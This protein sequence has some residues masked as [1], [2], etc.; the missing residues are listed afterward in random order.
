MRGYEAPSINKKSFSCPVCLAHTGQDWYKVFGEKLHGDD[1]PYIFDVKHISE[2]FE[3]IE[4]R[5]KVTKAEI[6]DTKRVLEPVQKSAQ[7][8]LPNLSASAI[9]SYQIH[10]ASN[11]FFS[12]CHVCHETCVWVFDRIICPTSN[13]GI[14]KPEDLPSEAEAVFNEAA[15]IIDLSPRAS[16]ALLRLCIEKICKKICVEMGLYKEKMDIDS[17]IQALYKNGLSPNLV[18]ALD[19]VRVHG[20]KAVHDGEIV[21]TDTK[22]D[23]VRLFGIVDNI[24]LQMITVRKSLDKLHANLPTEERQKIEKKRPTS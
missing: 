11:I 18:K 10:E 8:R 20:N 24:C 23:A 14:S 3:R 12:K 13:Q 7:K 15:S 17:M 1:I 16:A 6:E 21:L 4:K 9:T 2:I 5:P 22:E 19:I